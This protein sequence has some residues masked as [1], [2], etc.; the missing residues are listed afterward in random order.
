[1]DL[2]GLEASENHTHIVDIVAAPGALRSRASGGK[3]DFYNRQH[4]DFLTACE[5]GKKLA[6]MWFAKLRQDFPKYRFRVYY[7]EEDNPIVRFHRVREGEPFW[8]DEA[9]NAEDV[10]IGKVIVHD[11]GA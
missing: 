2:T 9:A 7:T 1:M 11:T 8:L 4:P 6:E 5:F 10:A 3:E